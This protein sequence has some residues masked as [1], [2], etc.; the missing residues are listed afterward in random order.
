MFGV[1]RVSLNIFLN[2]SFQCR[3]ICSYIIKLHLFLRLYF[4]LQDY[5]KTFL[6]LFLINATKD[7]I[8][9]LCCI[10]N[11]RTD[12]H[13]LE[14]SSDA[15]LMQDDTIKQSTFANIVKISEA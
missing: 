2:I 11:R 6:I 3:E 5:M 10:R 1:N 9:I 8:N 7:S 15:R 12:N 4:Y 14:P 13:I